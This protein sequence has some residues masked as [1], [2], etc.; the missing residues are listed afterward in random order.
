M[1][2]INVELYKYEPFDK[3]GYT[4]GHLQLLCY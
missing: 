1:T 3:N 2:D 4:R